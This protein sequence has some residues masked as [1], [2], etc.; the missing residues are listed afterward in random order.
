MDKGIL[1]S[2]ILGGA[3][4]I[5]SVIVLL[6]TIINSRG[7]KLQI[8]NERLKR[9]AKILAKQVYF[10]RFVEVSVCEELANIKNKRP[11]TLLKNVHRII[12]N[13]INVSYQSIDRDVKGYMDTCK[14]IE[15]VDVSQC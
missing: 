8:E 1:I 5:G 3:Q 6:A 2:L 11:I 9:D 15:P 13:D 7:S 4:I 12:A 14:N 10:L